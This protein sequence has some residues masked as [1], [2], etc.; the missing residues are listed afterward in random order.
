MYRSPS[1]TPAHLQNGR[2][3]GRSHSYK[4]HLIESASMS[5][6][7]RFVLAAAPGFALLGVT[8]GRTSER[9]AAAGSVVEAAP[10]PLG[11]LFLAA[12]VAVVALCKAAQEAP[13]PGPRSRRG[14]R[15]PV[16]VGEV[17]LLLAAVVG[18]AAGD[19]A[20]V[21]DAED[22]PFVEPVAA[23]GL[24]QVADGARRGCA[25]VIGRCPGQ[26]LPDL[27]VTRA[28]AGVSREAFTCLS[29]PRLEGRRGGL[30]LWPST[31]AVPPGAQ[32]AVGP[33]CHLTPLVRVQ[34]VVGGSVVGA[35]VG[36]ANQLSE[37]GWLLGERRMERGSVGIDPQG[38]K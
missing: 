30:V 16:A 18:D 6:Q 36:V 3:A 19:A 11:L 8:P 15:L 37:E 29:C 5:A 20:P 25:I 7:S 32:H 35:L 27:T 28:E 17:S 2:V 26:G 21:Q 23:E 4:E 1:R 10:K 33:G 14:G 31:R 12:G 22:E 9:Q 34:L 13:G 38:W 24:E